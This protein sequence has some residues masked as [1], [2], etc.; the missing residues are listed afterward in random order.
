MMTPR[1]REA[2]RAMHFSINAQ[3][4]LAF[5]F[6]ART[7]QRSPVRQSAAAHSCR[8]GGRTPGARTLRCWPR[9]IQVR[10]SVGNRLNSAS[11]STYTSAPGGGCLRT[12]VIQPF[13]EHN[14]VGLVPYV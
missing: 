12:L 9:N 7:L 13:F 8:F 3:N 1:F 4:A 11:S 6:F 10:V 14:P 5:R 2:E